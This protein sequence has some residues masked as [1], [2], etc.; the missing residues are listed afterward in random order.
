M[1]LR[2]ARAG[3]TTARVG[4]ATVKTQGVPG[5]GTAEARTSSIP[6]R[7]K[8]SSP[9]TLAGSSGGAGIT[10]LKSVQSDPSRLPNSSRASEPRMRATC[11]WIRGAAT[12]RSEEHTSELQSQSNLVC[13]LLLEKKKKK[14][15]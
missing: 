10:E 2:K 12:A 15:R 1:V 11:S 8:V 9:R 5:N 7:V 14:K 13:R 4:N 6:G 3:A